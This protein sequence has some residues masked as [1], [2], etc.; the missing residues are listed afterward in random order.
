MRRVAWQSRLDGY[1]RM[2]RRGVLGDDGGRRAADREA[3]IRAAISNWRVSLID[4]TATN[5]LLDFRPGGTGVIEVARP[6]AGEVFAHLTA[7]RMLAFRALTQRAGAAAAIPPAAACLLDANIDPGALDAELLRLMRCSNRQ[8]LDR[9]LPALYLAFGTLTW[10]DRDGTCYTSPVLLVPARLVATGPRQPAMLEATGDDPAINPALSLK[11]S[12]Y[13][14]RLPRVDDLAGVTLSGLLD[15]VRA[16]VASQR[17]WVVSETVMLSCFAPM[18]EAMYHDLVDHEDLVAAHPVVRALAVPGLAGAAVKGGTGHEAGAGAARALPP[19]I[20]PADSAQRA[21]VTA[22]LAGRSFTIDGPPGTGKSQTIANITGALLHAGKTVL[23]VSEKAAA[24]EVAAGRLTAAGLGPYLLELHSH[25]ATR[26]QVAVSLARALGTLPATPAAVPPADVA[27]VRPDQ[28]AAYA[29]AVNRVR[30]PLGYSLHDVLALIAGQQAV[31]AAPAADCAPMI[32]TATMLGEIR[33]TALVL[34]AAWRPAAQGRSF[35]WRGVTEHG[36]LDDRLYQAAS[37]LEAL[38][39]VV[40]V[41]QKLA[42][43]AG[44]TRPSDA[45]A[46]ARLL[47]HLQA[48]PQG[49]PDRWLT[50][51]T[52]D[53]VDAAVAQLAAALTAIAAREHE[54]S[55]AAGIPWSAIPQPGMPPADGGKALA[56]LDPA[57]ADLTG[58]AAG[59]ITGRAREFS[60]ATDRLENWLGTLSGLAGLLGLHAPVT[61]TD[62]GD[63]L[64]L[65]GLAAQSDRPERPWLSAAGQRAAS[66]AAQ[67]LHDAHRALAAAEA[68]ASAYFTP[69]ALRHDMGALA[70]RFI[71]GRRGLGKLSGNYRAARK[72]VRTVTREEVADETAHEHLGLAADWRLAADALAA[73]EARHAALLGPYYTG[74]ATDF[75][76]LGRALAHAATAVRCARGQDLSRAAGYICR[77]AAPDRI[78][79]GTV[80]EARQQEL[81]AWHAALPAAATRPEL[82][83]GTITGAIGWLRARLEQLQGASEFT[84]VVS[85]AV[86]G[87]LTFGQARQLAALR[88]AADAAHAQLAARDATFLDL[89]GPLYAGAAT[90]LGALRDRLEWARRLRAMITGG[91]GTPTVAHLDAAESAIPTGRLASAAIA[92][93]EACAAVLAAFSPQRRQELAAELDDYGAGGQLLETLFNDAGGPDQWHAYQAARAA[94]AAHGLDATVGFCITGQVEPGQVPQVIER[95]LLQAWADHHVRTDPALAPLQ[96]MSRD[97]L[98][99]G[100][101]RLD[102]ALTA[103][104]ATDII[105][106]CDARRPRGGTRESAVIGREAASDSIRMP[107]RDLLG[108]TRRLT[109]AIKPCFLMPPPAVSQ[110]LPAGMRFDVVI[111]DEASQISTSDAI[112]CIYRGG[113]VILAGDQ[114]QLPP[115]RPVGC[116]PAAGQGWP[117]EP[118]QVGDPES[119][120]DLAKGSGAFGSLA[121]RWHYRSRHEALISYSNAAFYG[122]RLLPIPGGGPEAGLELFHTE[123]T[124]QSQTSRDNPDEAARVAQRVVHHYDTRPGLSL[125]VVTFTQAQA[126][127]IETALGTAREQRPDLDR[128]F[129]ASRLRGFFIKT[130]GTVQGDERDVLIVSIG[131]GTDENGQVKTDF[132]PLTR[133]GGWRRLNV[134]ITR[135]RHRLEIIT[136]IH[137]GDIPDSAVGEGLKHLRRYLSYAAGA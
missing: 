127:A 101:Q 136:S 50:A 5:R 132:G 115:G 3:L 88:E 123:G 48:W 21:C 122:S 32:L 59:Q 36:P 121:L 58:L 61:F 17:G 44:L 62:A 51:D 83:N 7:G 129:T 96:R 120:L 27:G 72:T 93:Q 82:L 102:Q 108:Q 131:G 24:L 73:A 8:H 65:A 60:A 79:T 107:V 33:R 95:A 30:D 106:A 70:P 75:A 45:P 137:P 133:Q 124:Y 54:A 41:N 9:G 111:L 103:A 23:V 15:A 46:L 18:Q 71:A 112:N 99:G 57:C 13:L 105:R 20:L 26:K 14:I 113:A 94:L 104:A 119:V 28:L 109:Q 42:A 130:V 10:A 84:R 38:A 68:D 12:R 87:P 16:V 100:Y 43:A 56:A 117:A 4:V 89:L 128:F 67:V 22:A 66:G 29:E 80:T 85:E 81:P 2:E 19:L 53:A 1:V 69:D 52:L 34:A 98:A 135:A 78:V 77:D 39:E 97:V 55:Q 25:K 116:A 125:G 90:D 37:A 31:P 118:A 11:L 86:G 64:T 114:Q 76:R 126:D 134:A 49:V 91:P 92:W 110:H 40:R 35:P 47:D 63:L 74:R 6:A